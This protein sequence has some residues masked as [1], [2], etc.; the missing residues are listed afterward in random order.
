MLK[1]YALY[2]NIKLSCF[3]IDLARPN[4]GIYLGPE[5]EEVI[6]NQNISFMEA[7]NMA[8]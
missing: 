8:I 5:F 1:M 4:S 2:I 3:R 6:S 7:I